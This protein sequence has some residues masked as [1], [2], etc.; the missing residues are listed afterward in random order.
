MA[1]RY[2]VGGTANW[3]SAAG[4]KW[5]TTSGGAGGASVPTTADDVF[6][7][8]L[9]TGT[10]TI[11]AGNTGAKSINCTG[12]TGTISGTVSITVAG[13]VILSS[14]MTYNRTGVTAIT[15]TGT[16]TSA[17]KTFGNIT[18][19]GVGITVTLGDSVISSGF[20]GLTSGT[21]N[22]NNWTLTADSFASSNSNART[23][24]FG[25]GKIV[26]TGTAGWTTLTTTNLTISGTPVVDVTNSG[27]VSVTVSPGN[28]TVANTISFN[29]TA[30]TYALGVSGN[31][32]SLNFTGFS[33][34]LSNAARSVAG[35]IVFSSGM[36][37][38]AG[39]SA[40]TFNATSGGNT[41]TTN[42]KT[43]DFPITFNGVGGAWQLQDALTL[44][45]T[46][47]MTLTNG[48]FDAATYSVT[49][50]LFS[51][52][53][54]NTRT[55]SMGSGLWTLAGTGTVW[56]T[57]TATNLTFNKG[58]ADILLSSGSA[59]ARS[60]AG[61]GLS[62]NKITIGGATGSSTT[63]LQAINAT[64]F[65]STKPV[66]HTITIT[67]ATA[68]SFATWSVSGTA[69]NVVTLNSSVAGT[70]RTFN[71][72]NVT[73]GIDY[74]AVQDMECLQADRFYVGANSTDNGNNVNVY[75]TASPSVN[76]KTIFKN[77]FSP[78]FKQILRPIFA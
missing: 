29:F 74:L 62:F 49:L 65:A 57:A 41:I 13:S 27:S 63:N 58:T 61:G 55:I 5:A 39:T 35:S 1:D 60:F 31:V 21:L 9:S 15:G 47:T 71:L 23:I 24:A 66:A 22:L 25:T 42:G 11:A 16:I 8:N 3:D 45:S 67:S 75:F 72:T 44:G 77:V 70:R 73:S 34:T 78:V 37:V 43:L 10:V 40:T 48:S 12:F 26:I 53:N 7:D 28:P 4:T 56:T 59:T 33:G 52:T 69:G 50:G 2:W 46:R 54:S 20:V 68:L 19:D 17:G 36:T 38:S 64:E 76:V 32:R 30:G 14:G 51:S 18:M 6:F